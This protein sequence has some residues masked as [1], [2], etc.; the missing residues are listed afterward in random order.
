[1]KLKINRQ[2]FRELRNSPG[3][4][5]DLDARAERVADAAMAEYDPHHGEVNDGFIPNVSEGQNRARS[6]VVTGN[7]HAAR[8]NAAHNT[9]LRA[10]EAGRG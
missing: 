10:L 8:H 2:G 5:A 1:M 9:L 6:S 4:V 7:P 3:V